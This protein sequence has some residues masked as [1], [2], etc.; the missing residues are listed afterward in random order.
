MP[1]LAELVDDDGGAVAFRRRQ[2][3]AHQRGLAGA[4]EAGDDG[5]RNARAA[6]ALEP[7]A[8]QAG[9]AGGKEIVHGGYSESADAPR[10]RCAPSPRWGEGRGEGATGA[11]DRP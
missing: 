3:V 2:E 10:T 9:G 6:R 4:E 7:A 1:T 8:E 5:H 11:I